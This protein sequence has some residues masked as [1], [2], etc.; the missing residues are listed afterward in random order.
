[1]TDPKRGEDEK[2]LKKKLHVIQRPFDLSFMK[3]AVNHMNIDTIV[4]GM[5]SCQDIVIGLGL[6]AGNVRASRAKIPQYHDGKQ[7]RDFTR[8][9]TILRSKFFPVLLPVAEALLYIHYKS[10]DDANKQ[11]A[12]K[13]V[14]EIKLIAEDY[15]KELEEQE[16]KK[17]EIK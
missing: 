8:D 9:V 10:L 17:E 15:W 1:M 13:C 4:G 3:F 12:A 7:W 16:K 6:L 5:R 2:S 14:A 11:K